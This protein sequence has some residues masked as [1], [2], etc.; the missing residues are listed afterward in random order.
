MGGACSCWT[1]LPLSGDAGLALLFGGWP[2]RFTSGTKFLFCI[3]SL[4]QKKNMDRVLAA[5]LRLLRVP[6]EGRLWEMGFSTPLRYPL[7]S[8]AIF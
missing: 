1:W 4:Y 6:R 2:G 7:V 3:A 8:G 5:E